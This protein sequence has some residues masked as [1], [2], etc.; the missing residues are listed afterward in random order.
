MYYFARI[1]GILNFKSM[2]KKMLIKKF[3]RKKTENCFCEKV[4][5]EKFPME[6]EKISEIGGEIR[7][8]GE[9]HHC[10]RGDGHPWSHSY[11][12]ANIS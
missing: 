11:F 3:R 1:G 4:N 7:N 10:L 6:S 12:K 9:M 8:R 2:T 5:L